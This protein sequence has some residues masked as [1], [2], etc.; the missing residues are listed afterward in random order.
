MTLDAKQFN[1]VSVLT[2][3]FTLVYLGG[4]IFALVTSAI[5]FDRF[6]TVVGTPALPLF[7]YWAR[8][9]AP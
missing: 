7:G 2:G 3:I 5:T 9:N 6:L 1:F 4:A 8:G